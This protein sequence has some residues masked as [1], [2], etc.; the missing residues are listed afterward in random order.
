MRIP[1]TTTKMKAVI[2]KTRTARLR[3]DSAGGETG[4]KIDRFSVDPS[5]LARS[6]GITTV[7]P[8][9]PIGFLRVADSIR[10]K[11]GSTAQMSTSPANRS[12]TQAVV[13][14]SQTVA[15]QLSADHA[16]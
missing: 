10:A 5:A 6:R 14:E 12:V 1:S 13:D 8:F 3:I 4:S 7:T 16:G 2:A 11:C 9:L 15:D